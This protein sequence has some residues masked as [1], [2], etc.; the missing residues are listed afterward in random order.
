MQKM[1]V[2]LFVCSSIGFSTQD[3][4]LL[5]NSLTTH[6]GARPIILVRGWGPHWITDMTDLINFFVAD[7]FFSQDIYQ[8]GY[9]YKEDPETIRATVKNKLQAIFDRYPPGTK[10]DMIA[11]SLGHFVGLY[12]IMES[13]LSEQFEIYIGLAGV[14]HGQDPGSINLRRFKGETNIVLVPFNNE[15]ITGFMEAHEQAIARLKKCSLYSPS[16]KMVDRP[17]DSGAFQDGINIEIKGIGHLDFIHK[18]SVYETM[19][20]SCRFPA[21]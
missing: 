4:Q 17:Y 1:L 8:V 6:L 18:R 14:A 12:T 5:P 9:P 3:Q 10:F 20:S 19:R 2:I 7:G 16:D 21:R 15:F 11:H 13:E